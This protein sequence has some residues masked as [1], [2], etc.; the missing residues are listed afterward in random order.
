MSI[1]AYFGFER[2]SSTAIGA[3]EGSPPLVMSELVEHLSTEER[4]LLAKFPPGPRQQFMAYSLY[5]VNRPARTSAECDPFVR[6]VV[7]CDPRPS[8]QSVLRPEVAD[9]FD[10]AQ[11]SLFHM[12][13]AWVNFGPFEDCERQWAEDA[14][15]LAGHPDLQVRTC[16]ATLLLAIDGLH[17]GSGLN[18]GQ[19]TAL[20]NLLKQPLVKEKAD[21]YLRTFE[22]E[23]PPAGR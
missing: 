15:R 16:V 6:E 3:A 4:T 17:G 8:E 18:E 12:A 19:K 21:F 1:G 14:A 10:Q 5:H 9:Q 11:T 23:A 22:A 13:R 20:A 2:W 7:A